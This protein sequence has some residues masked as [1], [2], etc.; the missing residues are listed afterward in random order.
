MELTKPKQ[1][2]TLQEYRE[3]SK[4]KSPQKPQEPGL[5]SETADK[6]NPTGLEKEYDS[7][8]TN[9]G[10]EPSRSEKL[11]KSGSDD[12]EDIIDVS[13]DLKR[14]IIGDQ[15]TSSINIP[16]KGTERTAEANSKLKLKLKKSTS[17][18]DVSSSTP[19]IVVDHKTKVE[20]QTDQVSGQGTDPTDVP[21]FERIKARTNS[22]KSDDGRDSPVVS[23]NSHSGTIPDVIDLTE[24]EE[25]PVPKPEKT[26]DQSVTSKPSSSNHSVLS[27]QLKQPVRSMEG[28]QSKPDSSLPSFESLNKAAGQPPLAPKQGDQWTAARNT[29]FQS[30]KDTLQQSLQRNLS[31]RNELAKLLEKQKVSVNDVDFISSGQRKS[32]KAVPPHLSLNRNK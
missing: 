9:N 25:S 5:S 30:A 1:K 6:T 4:S 10:K 15:R 26:V 18:K 14:M 7:S 21:L 11:E 32:G 20:K 13:F 12:D 22:G 24:D 16:V 27:G 8:N 3:R 23:K 19:Q 17:D 29:G 28:F 31:R 2:L